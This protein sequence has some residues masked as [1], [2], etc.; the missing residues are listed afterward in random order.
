MDARTLFTNI[1]VVPVVVIRDAELAVPLAQTLLEAGLGAIEITLRTD[2][3]L[4]AIERVAAE[5]PE[6]LVGAGS[7]RHERQFQAICDAGANFAV[8]PGGT[9]KLL[10][11]ALR[12]QIHFVPGAVTAS[13]ILALLERGYTL[14]KFFPAELAGGRKMLQALAAPIP[15]VAF[16]PTGGISAQ[17]AGDYL[18][19]DCV[20]C[21]GGSWFVPETSLAEGDFEEIDRLARAA[22]Q[23]ETAGRRA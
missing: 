22:A 6:L 2:A 1:S 21:I 3:A 15:E 20:S 12:R 10:A 5:V 7:V 14:Q 19:L 11:E 9:E 13:E 23:L 8:S 16:F 4:A 18:Q 17:L